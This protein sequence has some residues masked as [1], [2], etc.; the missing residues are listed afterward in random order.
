ML[1]TAA[2]TEVLNNSAYSKSSLKR[3]VKDFD[4]KDIRKNVEAL[5]KRVEK[6]FDDEGEMVI[7]STG[8]AKDGTVV[9]GVW[10]ACERQLVKEAQRFTYLIGQCYADS[11][12]GLEFTVSDVEGA[13]SKHKI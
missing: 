3:V 5:F 8:K 10:T 7:A 6:H 4:A 13:F 1:Q 12:V 2:P 9:A 11:G